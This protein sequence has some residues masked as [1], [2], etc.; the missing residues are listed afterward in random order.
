MEENTVQDIETTDSQ[1]LQEEVLDETQ[2][3]LTPEEQLN[4]LIN[5]RMGS[6]PIKINHADLKFIKN[7]IT[8]KVEWK[9]PNEAYLVIISLLSI[10]NALSELDPKELS[11]AQINMPSSTLESIN[12]FLSRVTGK[13]LDSAQ[14]LFSVSMMIRPAMESLKKLDEEIEHLKKELQKTA[15]ND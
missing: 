4:S 5:R 12:F 8:Q 11:P 10:D 9:G 15:K 6:F 14:K 13:G 7:T 2:A 3:P 1:S